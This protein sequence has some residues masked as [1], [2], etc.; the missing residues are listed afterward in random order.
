MKSGLQCKAVTKSQAPEPEEKSTA[1]IIP[2][3]RELPEIGFLTLDQ[4]VGKGRPIPV[5]QATWYAW[6]KAGIAPQGIMLG[7]KRVYT[8]ASITKL[9]EN[10]ELRGTAPISA[11]GGSVQ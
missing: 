11:S 7:G 3:R 9:I 5:S 2:P 6:R 8:V 4:V 10:F 1:E